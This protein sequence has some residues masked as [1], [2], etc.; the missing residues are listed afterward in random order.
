MCG[1]AGFYLKGAPTPCS[2]LEEMTSRIAHRGP[3]DWGYFGVGGL[4]TPRLWKNTG[5]NPG[6]I[7]IGMGFRRLSILDLSPN[8]AQPM[9]TPDG[10]Y[11]LTF[12]GQLYNYLELRRE[13][14]NV[15][16]RST[17]DTE[18]LLHAL[19]QWGLDGL[20]RF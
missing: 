8:G 15:D 14:R 13:L 12:N 18:V 1:I 2:L 11:T 5:G 17:S 10:R 20:R 4:G 9:Q 19:A 3:D 7:K 6:P 16:F